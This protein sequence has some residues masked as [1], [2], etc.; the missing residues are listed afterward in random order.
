MLALELGINTL[1]LLLNGFFATAELAVSSRGPRLAAMAERGS[2][3]AKASLTHAGRRAAGA[4]GGAILAEDVAAYL[5]ALGLSPGSANTI[6]VVFVVVLITYLS[7]IIGELV[8]KQLALANSESVAASLARPM[9]TIAPIAA[10]AVRLL[11]TS[12]QGQRSLVWHPDLRQKAARRK[13]SHNGRVDDLGLDA[14]LGDQPHLTRVRDRDPAD[15]RADHSPKGPGVA[16]RLDHALVSCVRCRAKA[17]RWS[18]VMP[19]RPS[20]LIVPSASITASANT[21][22]LSNPHYPHG[23]PSHAPVVQGSWRARRQLRIV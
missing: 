11:E 19:I 5:V 7:L 4:F 20:R 8:P 21:R 15:V 9:T 2:V 22:W 23:L 13:P 10:P 18:R 17:S 1:L 16:G 12:A 3:G 6:G 14:S